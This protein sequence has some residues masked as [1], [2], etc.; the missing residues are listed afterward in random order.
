M[1]LSIKS[2]QL[3]KIDSI[4]SSIPNSMVTS[5]LVLPGHV[6]IKNFGIVRGITVRSRSVVGNFLGSLQSIFGGKISIYSNLCE[7][8]REEAYRL[9]CDSGVESGANA[10]ICMRY[11]GAEMRYG[12][13][14]VLCYGTA[15]YVIPEINSN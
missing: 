14:E 7:S 11:D 10:I 3:Q 4:S 9:M 12:M 15:V 13:A 5:G 2:K 1:S 8:A 6:I